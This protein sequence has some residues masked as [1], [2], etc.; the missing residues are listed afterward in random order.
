MKAQVIT[1]YK[2]VE[3]KSETENGITLHY[4]KTENG[5]WFGG[6]KNIE[7]VKKFIDYLTQKYK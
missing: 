7:S 6:T 5:K 4:K 2:G 3:I 1:K